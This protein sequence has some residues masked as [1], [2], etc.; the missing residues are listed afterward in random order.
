MKREYSTP[1]IV[2]DSFSLSNS[3]AGPC[4]YDTNTQ[5][6]NTCAVIIGNRRVFTSAV[7]GYKVEGGYVV[8]SGIYNGI[9]YHVPVNGFN[10]FNS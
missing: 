5:N 6:Q 4:S 3:I 8:D 2:F 7:L 1:D 9:C 10:V